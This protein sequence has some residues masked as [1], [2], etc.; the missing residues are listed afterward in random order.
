MGFGLWQKLHAAVKDIFRLSVHEEALNLNSLDTFLQLAKAQHNDNIKQ[1]S[2]VIPGVQQ[3]NQKV[4]RDESLAKEWS[5]VSRPAALLNGVLGKAGTY[6]MR[7]KESWQ[8]LLRDRAA[9]VLTYNDEQFHLLERIKMTETFKSIESLLTN[10]CIPAVLTTADSLADWYKMAQA[11]VL[12]SEILAKDLS[13]IETSWIE[14]RRGQERYH[15]LYTSKVDELV[16]VSQ[17]RT[18]VKEEADPSSQ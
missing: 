12:Q 10:E 11:V 4:L 15:A 8:H 9:R 16:E 18:N 1:M 3:L 13:G 5:S 14:T 17:R 7:L 6:V 2:G